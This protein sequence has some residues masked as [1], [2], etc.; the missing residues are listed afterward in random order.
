MALEGG[1]VDA[2]PK[3]RVDSIDRFGPVEIA[4][5]AFK[6]GIVCCTQNDEE[7]ARRQTRLVRRRHAAARYTQRRAF[8]CTHRNADG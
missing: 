2:C 7:V 5:M 8:L 1:H 6:P 3:D 4:A